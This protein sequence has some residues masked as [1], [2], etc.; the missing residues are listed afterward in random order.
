MN[1]T[2]FSD[3]RCLIIK[4]DI[5]RA[6]NRPRFYKFWEKL[7]YIFVSE[8]LDFGIEQNLEVSTEALGF[9]YCVNLKN[10]NNV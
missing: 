5:D 3:F 1:E 4:I 8:E 10:L 9:G 2:Y 7:W 6:P